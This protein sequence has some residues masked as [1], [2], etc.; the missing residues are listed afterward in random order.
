MSDRSVDRTALDS[1][2][3]EPSSPDPVLES[4][5]RQQLQ[6]RYADPFDASVG[7]DGTDVDGTVE[8]APSDREEEGEYDFRLF[9]RP[10]VAS[11]GA[12][13]ITLRSASPAAG[14]ESGLTGRGR[15][16]GYYFT[17]ATGPEL[18]EQYARAAV[19]SGDVI[20]GRGVRWVCRSVLIKRVGSNL[21]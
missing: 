7:N 3:T 18:A 4:R 1:P 9:A 5:F 16:D 14:R 15:P 20:E 13:R 8:Q 12:R 17:G 21:G 6:R 2:T 10:A 11:I 19:S